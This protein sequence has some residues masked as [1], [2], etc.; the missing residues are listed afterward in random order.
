MSG[1]LAFNINYPVVEIS[2]LDAGCMGKG[3]RSTHRRHTGD[4]TLTVVGTIEQIQAIATQV[5]PG[6]PEPP[7]RRTARICTSCGA[8]LRAEWSAGRC[9]ECIDNGWTPLQPGSENV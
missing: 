7:R 4:A 3:C 8:E 5:I 2:C 9:P 1:D 6:W